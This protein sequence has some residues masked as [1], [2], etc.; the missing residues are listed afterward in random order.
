[1]GRHTHNHHKKT[2]TKSYH[3]KY[4]NLQNVNGRTSLPKCSKTKNIVFDKQRCPRLKS[5][6]LN[7]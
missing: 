1:M 4:L 7:T 5:G 2:N 6:T 3:C